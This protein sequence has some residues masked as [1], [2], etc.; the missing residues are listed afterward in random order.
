MNPASDSAGKIA[1]ATRPPKREMAEFTPEAIPALRGPS[2]ESTAVVNGATVSASPAAKIS[3]EGKTDIQ[4]DGTCAVAA[5]TR[6]PIP[7]T[8]GPNVIGIRGP[9]RSA[10]LPA[11]GEPISNSPVSGS[12]LAPA[13]TAEKPRACWTSRTRY[14]LAPASAA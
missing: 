2:A 10:S 3:A 6:S 9:M 14:K 4:Y 1:T 7:A 11:M 5:A 13:A 8:A 12:R